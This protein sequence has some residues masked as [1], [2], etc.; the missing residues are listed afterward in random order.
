MPLNGK[1]KLSILIEQRGEYDIKYNTRYILEEIRTQFSLAMP[2]KARRI[3]ITMLT[4][5]Q[6]GSLWLGWADL[7]AHFWSRSANRTKKN[8]LAQTGLVGRCLLEN[9][10]HL[11]NVHNI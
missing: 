7:T 9:V 8:Y 2:N 1:T 4:F 5:S 3:Q 11:Q 6:K 10:H